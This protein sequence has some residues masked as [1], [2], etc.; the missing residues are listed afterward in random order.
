VNGTSSLARLVRLLWPHANPLARGVDRFESFTL[1]MVT[2][3]SVFLMPIM[4]VIGSLTHASLA[5]KGEQEA[6]TRHEV[7]ATLIDDAPLASADGHGDATIA[8]PMV[9][10]TWQQ[11][12]ASTWTG[13]VKA[14]DGLRA[15][16]KVN[17]WLDN[18][19]NSVVPAP[20]KP[21]DAEAAAMLLAFVG[22]LGAVGLL[23]LAQFGVHRVLDRRR[24]R[25]WDEQW[26]Q[27]EPDWNTY[28]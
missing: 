14:S 17:I 18:R 3:F 10:A 22:W 27:V 28:R 19:D 21:I 15:G 20:I 11:A 6:G 24:V 5:E 12:D 4:L 13:R 1:L 25:D 26:A 2:M 9:R 8:K 23:A 16:A 7:V